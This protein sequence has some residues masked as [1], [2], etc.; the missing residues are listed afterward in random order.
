MKIVFV[1]RFFFPDHSAT[2]Q[3]LTDLAFFLAGRGH[4]VHVVTSRL[5][6]DDPDAVFPAEETA[7]GVVVHRVWTTRFGRGSLVGRAFDYLTFYASAGRCLRKLLVSG[8]VVVAKTDPPLISV[9]AGWA[10]RRRGARLVNW[11]QDVFPEV[12]T[13]LGVPGMRGVAARGLRGLRD[14]S[15][16]AAAMN[17]V[18]G[19]RM[20]QTL[21]ALGVARFAIRVIPNWA[22]GGAIRPMP[23]EENPLRAPWGLSG[24][25][26]V[27][28][29]GNMGR[30]HEFGTI[31]GAADQLQDRS[32]IVF[33]FIGD[34]RY[35]GWL[36]A[37]AKARGLTNVLF[38]PYQPRDGLSASLAVPDVHL[39]TLRPEVEGLVV[40][41]KFYGAAAAGRP[42]VFVG[43][44]EGEIGSL[45]T[46]EDCGVAIRQGDSASLARCLEDLAGAPERAAAMGAR[47]REV[48]TARFDREPACR[49]WEQLLGG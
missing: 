23:A 22:D 29:S 11:L 17:V 9:V 30:V 45:L 41:S 38:K 20:A 28:Y 27:G 7:Q 15:L 12:A 40:P 42:T 48:F 36:E 32:R 49:A 35:R 47:A 13:A 1:N 18:L 25:F 5:S 31:L 3:L 10:A 19:E 44:P 33:L 8:D 43:D 6:Y 4:Q 37:Q 46:R 39:V 2:S 16:R 26:V 14:R 21:T 24:K 34:G